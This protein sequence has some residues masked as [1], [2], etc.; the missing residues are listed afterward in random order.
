MSRFIRLT[1][2]AVN[3]NDIQRIVIEPNKY[4]ILTKKLDGFTWNIG[5]FGIGWLHS[6][7]DKTEVCETKHPIDYKI[8]SDWI[9]KIK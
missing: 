2:F 5:P 8:I 4:Y 1:N 6:D 7:T 9:N 3:V